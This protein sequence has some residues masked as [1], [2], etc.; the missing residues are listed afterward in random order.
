MT[1]RDQRPKPCAGGCGKTTRGTR[2]RECF[3]K[4]P[5]RER[6]GAYGQFQ[7]RPSHLKTGTT[8]TVNAPPPRDMDDNDPR[9]DAV[10][11]AEIAKDAELARRSVARGL[12]DEPDTGKGIWDMLGIGK[13]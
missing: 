12:P 2:C 1:N 7:L 9:S 8:R 6:T 13:K 3:S 11:E 5:A 4:I 10:I